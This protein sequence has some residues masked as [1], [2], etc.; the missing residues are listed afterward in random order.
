MEGDGGAGIAETWII[1]GLLRDESLNIRPSS[2]HHKN[3]DIEKSVGR[4]LG[5]L[6]CSRLF[7]SG[8]YPSVRNLYAIRREGASILLPSHR[9]AVGWQAHPSDHIWCLRQGR[10]RRV[11]V[12]V[13]TILYISLDGARN[14]TGRDWGIVSRIGVVIY[15]NY[16]LLRTCCGAYQF[17]LV[18]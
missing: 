8:K 7:H 11:A 15:P 14:T 10:W 4:L 3:A 1:F 9:H 5:I 17:D 2:A 6:Q 13:D 16:T 18:F 12:L